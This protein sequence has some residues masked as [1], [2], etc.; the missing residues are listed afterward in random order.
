MTDRVVANTKA[1]ARDRDSA[2]WWDAL[3]KHQLLLQHCEDCAAFRWPPR[4]LCGRCASLDWLWI[5]ASGTGTVAS[6]NVTWRTAGTDIP[7]PYVVL[8]VRLDDQPDILMPGS[9]DGP[10]DGRDLGVGLQVQVG[11]VDLDDGGQG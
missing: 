9:Y 3:N 6:W 8:L 5:P 11:F 1:P 4:D 7:V 2:P 10:S